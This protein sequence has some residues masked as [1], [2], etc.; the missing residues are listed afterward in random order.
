M[1]E[2]L[3]WS[4]T[5]HQAIFEKKGCQFFFCRP[6]I[7]LPCFLPPCQALQPASKVSRGCDEGLWKMT[8]Q[9][10]QFLFREIMGEIGL[11]LKNFPVYKHPNLIFPPEKWDRHFNWP[12]FNDP[13]SN[14]NS[15]ST[16]ATFC[17]SSFPL[18]FQSLGQK[19]LQKSFKHP[20][21]PSENSLQRSYSSKLQDEN[22]KICWYP[23]Q[24]EQMMSPWKTRTMFWKG[25]YRVF[26]QKSLFRGLVSFL[27]GSKFSNCQ[28]KQALQMLKKLSGYNVLR[29]IQLKLFTVF[30]GHKMITQNGPSDMWLL[31]FF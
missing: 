7:W 23:P 12:P 26:Q 13:L 8:L 30:P 21:H 20:P 17:T 11:C 24:N 15:D 28:A 25:K 22:R 16:K 14:H 9:P 19:N 10:K 27:R 1:E 3:F 29:F 6:Q 5:F 2:K 31:S 4:H 18:P